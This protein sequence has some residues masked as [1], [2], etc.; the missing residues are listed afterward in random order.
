[1]K[2]R[3][4]LIIGGS[5]ADL[6]DESLVLFNYTR[7][8]MSDPTV[9]KNS[10]SQTVTLPGTP[11]NNAIFGHYFR[12]DRVTESSASGW[13]GRW[14]NALRQT[15]FEIR[16]ER[17]GIIESGYVKLESVTRKGADI[18]SYGVALYGGLGAFFYELTYD[19]EGNK[20][21]LASLVYNGGEVIPARDATPLTAATLRTAWAALKAG[22]AGIWQVVNFA[23]CYNGLPKCKFDTDKAVYKAVGTS[24]MPNLYDTKVSEDISYSSKSGANGYILL[25]MA[26]EHTEWEVQD[27]R[28]Y[29]QRPVIRIKAIIEALKNKANTGEWTFKTD[30]F[31]EGIAMDWQESSWMTLPMFDRDNLSPNNC[32]LNDLLSGTDTPAAYLIGWAKMF[33][34]VFVTDK[35]TK[36]ITMMSRNEFY[37]SGLT[38]IGDRIDRGQEFSAAPYGIESRYY[39][40]GLDTYGEEAASYEERYGR[41]YGSQTVDTGYEFDAESKELYSG[42][43]FSGAAMALEGSQA[44]R[45]FGGSS[46]PE[47]GVF[48]NYCCKFPLLGESVTWQLYGTNAAGE[49]VS[50]DCEPTGQGIAPF[51]YNA[52]RNGYD[53][54][55]KVQLHGADNEAEDGSGV[56]LFFNGFKDLPTYR[57]GSFEIAAVEF[58]LSDDNAAMTALNDG[59]P[60]WDFSTAESLGVVPVK[61]LPDFS[62]W[63]FASDGSMGRSFDFGSPR[64]IYVPGVTA[65][66]AATLYTGY[67]KRY[68]GDRLDVDGKVVTCWVDLRGLE[69]GEALLRRLWAFDGAIWAL[70]KISNWSLTTDGPTQCEFVK[71][72]V[73]NNYLSGQYEI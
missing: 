17:G 22:T 1:M 48:G 65:D 6:D 47:Y 2:R 35:A 53:S 21:T 64:E 41:T 67:W 70:N 61:S 8:E 23:P 4:S 29:L 28:A 9:V 38:D 62:R 7:E 15:P 63:S 51:A 11:A 52:E 36:T 44:F 3:I 60:C 34:C 16:D 49:E 30:L 73:P 33:G 68:L 25:Q 43:P 50:L 31:D 69:V 46:D 66:D 71:V 5:P 32:F 55:A 10:Y 19:G 20:K 42:S 18:C 14:F 54:W 37:L 56:L 59:T 12:A 57:Q 24:R 13:T 39:V 45:V 72:K 40:L 58:R 27:L 26:K